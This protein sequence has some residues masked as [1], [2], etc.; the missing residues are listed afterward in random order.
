MLVAAMRAEAHDRRVL[1]HTCRPDP[2]QALLRVRAPPARRR[3]G[4]NRV[5][6]PFATKRVHATPSPPPRTQ[7][8]APPRRPGAVGASEGG[9]CDRPLTGGLLGERVPRPRL[10]GQ[11][12]A[13]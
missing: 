12:G 5:P 8:R 7:Q 13:D 6:Y 3:H 11:D 9:L 2:P 1:A 10:G 4:G